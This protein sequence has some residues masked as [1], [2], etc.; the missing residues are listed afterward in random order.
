MGSRLREGRLIPSELQ[1]QGLADGDAQ[2]SRRPP[3]AGW[4][5][6]Q[7]EMLGQLS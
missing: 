7:W 3:V 4:A 1:E 6:G 2:V 5:L